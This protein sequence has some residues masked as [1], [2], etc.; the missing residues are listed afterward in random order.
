MFFTKIFEQNYGRK[1][2]YVEIIITQAGKANISNPM[3]Y[4]LFK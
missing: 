2:L 4:D 1:L 3:G